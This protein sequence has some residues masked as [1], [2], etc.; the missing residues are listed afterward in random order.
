MGMAESKLS[1]SKSCP[2]K[3]IKELYDKITVASALVD[4]EPN[5]GEMGPKVF[6]R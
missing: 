2:Q 1:N 6:K 4:A 5:K 3:I